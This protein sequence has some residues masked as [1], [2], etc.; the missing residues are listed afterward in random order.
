MNVYLRGFTTA[1]GGMLPTWWLD[2]TGLLSMDVRLS[3]RIQNRGRW[4]ATCCG[5]ARRKRDAL[6]RGGHRNTSRRGKLILVIRAL[7][8]NVR[9]LC[10]GYM[11]LTVNNACSGGS[12]TGRLLRGVCLLVTTASCMVVK[13]A[14]VSAAA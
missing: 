9:L 10:L 8:C 4:Y 1:V 2:T 11:C 14:R 12:T 13:R 6:R 5:E 7:A 3:A